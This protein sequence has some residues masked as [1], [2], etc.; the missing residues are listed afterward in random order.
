M[1]SLQIES[2]RAQP[3]SLELTTER[4]VLGR[5]P[6][7]DLVLKSN[8]ASRQ[9]AQIIREDGQHF[10]EDLGSRN[11]TSLNGASVTERVLL[12][13]GDKLN[14]VD[15]V[16]KFVLSE[17]EH[18][19]QLLFELPEILQTQHVNY[20]GGQWRRLQ[21]ALRDPESDVFRMLCQE[22][23]H[24]IVLDVEAG[25]HGDHLDMD[26]FLRNAWERICREL[27]LPH[28]AGTFHPQQIAETLKSEAPALFCIL[29]VQWLSEQEIHQLRGLGFTQENHHVLYVGKNS[30]LGTMAFPLAAGVED[31]TEGGGKDVVAIVSSSSSFAPSPHETIR[32][33]NATSAEAKLRAILHLNQVIATELDLDRMLAVVLEG[34]LTLFPQCDFAAVLLRGPDGEE[35]V[36]RARRGRFEGHDARIRS[37]IAQQ[38][39]RSGQALLSLEAQSPHGD[40]DSIANMHI[41]PTMCAPLPARDGGWDGV[42]YLT[43]ATYPGFVEEDLEL[44]SAVA[45]QVGMGVQ[46]RQLHE[47]AVRQQVIDH[48]LQLA[49]EIQRSFLPSSRPSLPGFEFADYYEAARTVGGDYYDYVPLD[50]NR[51]VIAIGDVAGR[52]V[53]AALMMARLG[54]APQCAIM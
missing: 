8:A 40:S 5:S 6:D 46:M 12:Q 13:D 14:I 11:G 1:A 35:L 44:L 28:A 53:A 2:G 10:V 24:V 33:R 27:E 21:D 17:S 4:V 22:F 31:G 25:R 37:A 3:A 49:T 52:G 34:V 42:L 43:G 9:H 39:L 26:T 15:T 20:S 19:Q 32:M 16:I 18:F 41:T 23:P 47:I 30:G 36:T 54:S 51:L 48:D 7:C 50:S 38:S 45:A 29:N